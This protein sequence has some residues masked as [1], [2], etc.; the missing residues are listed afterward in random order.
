MPINPKH[1]PAGVLAKLGV[2]AKRKDRLDREAKAYQQSAFDLRELAS[3]GWMIWM[4][5]PPSNNKY[6]RHYRNRVVI[7]PDG[8][9]YRTAVQDFLDDRGVSFGGKRLSVTIRLLANTK[10]KF[11]LDNFAKVILDSL[12]HAGVYDNDSQ[13]DL[14]TMERGLVMAGMGQAIVTIGALSGLQS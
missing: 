14:L 13:I 4:P 9:A 5:W 8:V 7:G 12:A 1:L 2:P 6:W 11:D 10:R 3:G